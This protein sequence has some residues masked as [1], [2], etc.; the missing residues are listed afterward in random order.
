M[1]YENVINHLKNTL[2]QAGVLPEAENA[3]TTSLMRQVVT[4]LDQAADMLVKV[5]ENHLKT[6]QAHNGDLNKALSDVL[7]FEAVAEMLDQYQLESD[8]RD[9]LESPKKSQLVPSG[10]TF[11][12]TGLHSIAGKI[13]AYVREQAKGQALTAHV[14]PYR[15]DDSH[16]LSC[17]FHSK[18]SDLIIPLCITAGREQCGDPID[19]PTVYD[20]PEALHLAGIIIRGVKAEIEIGRYLNETNPAVLTRPLQHRQTN[21]PI[22]LWEE[23][24]D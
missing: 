10:F 12:D 6:S 16:M 7:N 21:G 14:W 4:L 8:A 9:A 5:A 22:N 24:H 15:H 1:Y 11:T 13:V 20:L 3:A 18:D 23:N 17:D 19:E 2:Q